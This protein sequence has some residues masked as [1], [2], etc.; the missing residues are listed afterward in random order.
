VSSAAF[1]TALREGDLAGLRACPKADLHVHGI[2]GGSRSYLRDRSGRDIAPVEGVLGSMAEM[3]AWT[4]RQVGDLFSGR[5]GRGLAFEATFAQ[6]RLDGVTLLEVG[7]DAWGVTLHGGSASGVWEM[8]TAA[9]ERG[10]PEVEWRPQIGVSRHCRVG[11]IE[12]WLAPLLE[13][14]AFETLDLYGDEFAQPIEAFLP[15][16][17]RARDAG[18][19]LKAHVGEWG[20]ADDVLKAFE[21][22]ELDEVQHGIAAADSALVMARLAD[23][24]V[25]LNVCPTSNLKLGRVARLED[26]PIRRLYDA[27]VKVTVNTDDALVFGTSL[28]EE[29][30]ALFQCGL[31][32]AAELDHIR[33]AAFD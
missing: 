14:A 11:D 19:R 15:V 18:L 21:L 32:T 29:F 31:M 6:A 7:E 17:R 23:A 24:G 3:D 26:H 2:C 20:T 25:R 33:L 1:Q 28:S 9:H 10:G 5:V 4:Q 13:L 16:Y 27:G 8:L 12:A 22:L 30:L